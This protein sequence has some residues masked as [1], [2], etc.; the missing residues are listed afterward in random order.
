MKACVL[1]YDG[2][3]EFEV[4]FAFTILKNNIF[5]AALENR[6]YKS[7]ENQKYLPDITIGELNPEEIDL[8]I[9]PGGDLSHLYE[10]KEIIEFISALDDKKK[11]IAG[12]CGGVE[13]MAKCGVLD[14]K[15]CTGD[16][17][18]IILNET[19]KNIYEKAIIQ[20][21]DFV[22]DGNCITSIG[23]AYVEFALELGKLMKVYKNDEE[24]KEDYN[25]LKNIKEIK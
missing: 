13:L 19:N 5:S 23:K 9:I 7:E 6:V 18:G 15:K 2:F 3:C 14:N 21:G 11:Y 4:V 1:Y 16:S 8:F 10:N 24:V 12:I 25:W 20:A 22:I 17:Q